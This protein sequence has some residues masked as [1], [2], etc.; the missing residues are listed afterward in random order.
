MTAQENCV[1][2]QTVRRWIADGTIQRAERVGVR[3]IRIDMDSI[4]AVSLT[5]QD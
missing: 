4:K 5:P 1:S 2:Q 3:L